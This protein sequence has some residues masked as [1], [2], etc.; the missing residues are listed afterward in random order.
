MPKII[1]VFDT[2]AHLDLDDFDNDREAVIQRTLTGTFPGGLTPDELA[3]YTFETAGVLL[4]GVDAASACRVI[5]LTE[6]TPKFYAAVAIHPNY[7][8]KAAEDDWQTITEL[9]NRD[10]V[11]AIGE[12]GLDRYWD[13]VPF[14]I[15]RDFFHR[16]IELSKR[17]GKPVVIH[18]RDAWDDVLPILRTQKNLRGVIH[19]FSGTAQ[20]AAECVQLG[21]YI[22]FAGS[23]TY[24]NKKFAPLWEAAKVVPLDRLLVETDSPF[25]VPHPYRGKLQRNEPMMSAMVLL[26]LS[27]LRN[28]PLEVIAEAT[29][30][31]TFGLIAGT[32]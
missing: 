20:Q 29:A 13:T 7:T 2:H 18:N 10:N 19:A 28:E 30:A 12:T 31:N 32:P 11:V 24:R 22:S 23:L 17:T 16:H 15:Q 6:K 14:D 26:R 8:G 25:M 9:A 3:G 27:Q 21:Y 4:P 1:S 5:E